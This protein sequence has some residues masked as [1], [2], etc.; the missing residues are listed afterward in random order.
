MNPQAQT[1]TQPRERGFAGRLHASLTATWMAAASRVTSFRPFGLRS[2]ESAMQ[3]AARGRLSCI[4][5]PLRTKRPGPE[6][7]HT[8]RTCGLPIRV[9]SKNVDRA[10][11][12]EEIQAVV[13]SLKVA[14]IRSA[15]LELPQEILTLRQLNKYLA[16]ETCSR[17]LTVEEPAPTAQA[18]MN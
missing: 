13:R 8:C 12:S 10:L 15:A 5:M 18:Q 7:R 16:G 3:F 14:G 2:K 6:R 9:I 17:T 4:C 11:T 1:L